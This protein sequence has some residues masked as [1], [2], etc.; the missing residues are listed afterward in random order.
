MMERPPLRIIVSAYSRWYRSCSGM[1]GWLWPHGAADLVLPASN[2]LARRS[3]RERAQSRLAH[4]CFLCCLFY[5]YS[6]SAQQHSFI[7]EWVAG[8]CAGLLCLPCYPRWSIF[9]GVNCR[10]WGPDNAWRKCND[11]GASGSV[12]LPHFSPQTPAK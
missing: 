2:R 12:G 1:R 10:A 11:D 3:Q 5:L 7:I 9:S 4:R 8:G 6:Y